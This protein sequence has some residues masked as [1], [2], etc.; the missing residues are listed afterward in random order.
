[1]MFCVPEGSG[2]SGSRGERSSERVSSRGKQGYRVRD[3]YSAR[4][5]NQF[6]RETV[7][8][9]IESKKKKKK[10]G[11]RQNEIKQVGLRMDLCE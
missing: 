5:G 7:I 8:K 2:A 9:N 3:C 10:K 1:M 11:K 6:S 4:P